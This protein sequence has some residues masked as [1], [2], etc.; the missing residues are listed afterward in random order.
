MQSPGRPAADLTVLSDRACLVAF[1]AMVL[2]CDLAVYEHEM[3]YPLGSGVPF[4]TVTA[5]GVARRTGLPVA[6]AERALR[7]L[8]AAGLAVS[9]LEGRAWRPDTD[10]LAASAD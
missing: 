4:V 5:T 10:A 7:R 2:S 6:D 8:Q 3:G 9:D 1:A